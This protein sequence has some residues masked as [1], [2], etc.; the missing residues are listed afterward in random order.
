MSDHDEPPQVLETLAALD[1]AIHS[2]HATTQV[3]CLF[4]NFYYYPVKR[5]SIAKQVMLMSWISNIEAII[6]FLD[7]DSMCSLL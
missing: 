5:A 7:G 1:R 2:P 4:Y 3:F 6:F